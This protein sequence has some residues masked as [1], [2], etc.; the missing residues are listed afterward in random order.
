[1][2]CT[3]IFFFHFKFRI[4]LFFFFALILSFSRRGISWRRWQMSSNRWQYF[5]SFNFEKYFFAN[6]SV[7]NHAR[8]PYIFNV[9]ITHL[10]TLI[11]PYFQKLICIIATSTRFC[12]NIEIFLLRYEPSRQWT[13]RLYVLRTKILSKSFEDGNLSNLK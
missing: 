11:V 13:L 5:G 9:V 10:G 2:S 6:T 1:M 4:F 8:H 7:H 12:I 3:K